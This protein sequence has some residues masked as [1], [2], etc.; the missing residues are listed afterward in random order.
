MTYRELDQAARRTA[1]MLRQRG[2]GPG[3]R[4]AMIFPNVPQF[5]VVYFG[6]L[7]TG[8]AA[9]PMNVLLKRREIRYRLEDTG[10]KVCLAL[11]PMAGEVAKAV[12]Q[13]PGTELIV[14]E[15]GSEPET[16]EAGQ[17]FLRLLAEASGSGDMHPTNP[18]DTA[19]I[20]YASA[21]DGVMKGAE[22]THFNLFQNALTI[23]EYALGYY[24][25]D[26][27]ITVLPLFHGFGQSTMMNAPF[28]AGS[29]VALIPQFDPGAVFQVIQEE[30]ATLLAVVPTMLHVMHH[31]RKAP[32]YDLS[33][34]RC[35]IAGGAALPADLNKAFSERFN[36][37]VVEG[38][39]LTETSPVVCWNPPTPE[40]N[41]PGTLGVPIW[42]VRMG[43]R[44]AD[45]AWADTGE[46]GEI[47][48]RGH[49]VMKGYLNHPETTAAVLRDGWL[50]TG[51]Y[52]L[53]DADGYYH[54]KGLKKSLI[55][56][57]GMN[58][59]PKEVENV[60]R[61]FPGVADVAVV[62]HHDPVR[63]EEVRA[64]VVAQPGVA[65]EPHAV[66]G[67][68]RDQIAAYKAPRKLQ[69]V[70]S[71]PRDAERYVRRDALSFE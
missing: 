3:D 33:S 54:F 64:F 11:A 47:V 18:D 26:T 19:V 16:P 32:N 61:E 46:V 59:Y 10:A 28:L 8:A 34:L 45:G 13:T 68:V 62:G 5:A 38:Y 39:G 70:E 1:N 56:R 12:A 36:V 44:R 23:K 27:C 58:V 21:M 66:I 57:A 35:V 60:I 69:V 2:V 15:T 20:L 49:N 41:R 17:S 9:I 63:G 52:G 43:I 6:I 67:Y 51:D 37:V 29:T 7:Y 71:I 48:V 22:L 25:D 65:L 53:V 30:Q 24:P 4:V 14:A 40:L 42:G 50:Y 31:Y 55:N